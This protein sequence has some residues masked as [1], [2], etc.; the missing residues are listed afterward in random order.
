MNANEWDEYAGDWDV[1]EEVQLYAHKALDSLEKKVVPFYPSLSECRVLD[2]GCGTGLLTERL[3]G[4]CGQVVAV[5]TS[6]KMIEV[7]RNKLASSGMGNV[8][9]S[10]VP[11]DAR[12]IKENPELLAAFDLVVASSVC[13]F[14]H[15]YESSLL[16][17]SS[18]MKPGAYFVQWDWMENM[19]GKRIE[20]AFSSSGLISQSIGQAFA[21]QANEDSKPVI[22][23]VGRKQS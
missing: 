5:D 8:T 23:G 16:D 7:L 20:L 22:M 6:E 2:F 18:M 11:I 14:L 19:P 17:I 3:A 21:M 4:R 15:D 1:N 10:T 12:S 9:V 13:S